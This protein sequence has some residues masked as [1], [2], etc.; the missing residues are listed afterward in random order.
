MSLFVAILESCRSGP[1]AAHG[2]VVRQLEIRISLQSSSTHCGLKR[3]KHLSDRFRE[4]QERSDTYRGR[5]VGV[6]DFNSRSQGK[7]RVT[8][9][10]AMTSG[11]LL[12][13]ANFTLYLTTN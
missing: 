4:C 9:Q 11:I 6:M 8:K 3:L 12:G 5:F 7:S 10:E 2:G 13:I 1:Q